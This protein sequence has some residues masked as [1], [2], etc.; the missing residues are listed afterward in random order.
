MPTRK[1]PD[2]ERQ[3][4]TSR[5]PCRDPDHLPRRDEEREPGRYE[6]VCAACGRR[7]EFTVWPVPR[8]PYLLEE[9]VVAVSVERDDR[10]GSYE[11]GSRD[12]DPGRT[13]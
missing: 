9:A 2:P 4:L 6:H 3:H 5:T 8:A 13:G 12:Y 1:L 11:P 7:F 10:H